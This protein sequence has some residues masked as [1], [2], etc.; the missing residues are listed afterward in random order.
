MSMFMSF[1]AF[2]MLP[3]INAAVEN[4]VNAITWGPWEYN[5]AFIVPTLLDG[6]ARDAGNSPTTLLRPGLIMGITKTTKQA[7]PYSHLGVGG[8][9]TLYGVLLYDTKVVG[10]DGADYDRWFGYILVG[11]NVKA[12]A[13]I[14]GVA[15]STPGSWIG[16]V[17]DATIRAL[18]ANRFILDDQFWA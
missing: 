7:I 16:G 14:Y 8:V 5:R 11:G 15:A 18:F 4:V 2:G 6:A 10:S 13:L 1:D 3:G 17:Q 9:E 12:N